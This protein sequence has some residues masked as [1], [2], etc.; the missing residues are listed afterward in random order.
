MLLRLPLNLKSSSINFTSSWYYRLC[1]CTQF[2]TNAP[3][4]CL[5]V[6]YNSSSCPGTRSV[7]QASLELREIC[8]S[9]PPKT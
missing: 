7:D 3:F 6:L 1:H 5:T 2:T 8:L 9:L 4:L